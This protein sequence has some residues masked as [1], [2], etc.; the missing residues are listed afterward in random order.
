MKKNSLAVGQKVRVVN[1]DVVGKIT[2]I[3]PEDEPA[4]MAKVKT[5][6]GTKCCFLSHLEP[7]A[8]TSIITSQLELEIKT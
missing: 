5:A 7:I 2:E 3:S 1:S 4:P 8:T 6:D